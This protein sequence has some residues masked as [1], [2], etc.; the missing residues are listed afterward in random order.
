LRVD[1][2]EEAVERAVAV[3]GLVDEWVLLLFCFF[4]AWGL[5]A[6]CVT[7]VGGVGG[8]GDARCRSLPAAAW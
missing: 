5:G 8:G 3:D 6:A 7:G 4:V 1:L 2:D